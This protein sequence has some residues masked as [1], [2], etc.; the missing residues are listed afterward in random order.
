L[1]RKSIHG[2]ASNIAKR[3]ELTMSAF[4]RGQQKRGDGKYSQPAD[5]TNGKNDEQSAPKDV[6]RAVYDNND[7]AA[8]R[9]G[10]PNRSEN[11][12]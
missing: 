4:K 9:G 10:R 8:V 12:R 11:G 6:S 3:K 7:S 1:A 5:I 2:G